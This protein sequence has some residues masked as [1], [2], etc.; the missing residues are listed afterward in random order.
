M[1]RGYL[2]HL[3]PAPTEPE[4]G[5]LGGAREQYRALLAD[6][7]ASIED[8]I[9]RADAVAGGS[10]SAHPENPWRQWAEKMGAFKAAYD[11]AVQGASAHSEKMRQPRAMTDGPSNQVLRPVHV[12]DSQRS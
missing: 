11:A 2:T 5:I 1:I 3:E 12:A 6:A 8:L 4:A 7:E 9:T 10:E